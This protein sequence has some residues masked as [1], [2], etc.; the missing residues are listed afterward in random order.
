MNSWYGWIIEQSL[1][2]QSF[3]D[4]VSTIKMKSEEED[5]KEHIV[6]VPISER[7]QPYNFLNSPSFNLI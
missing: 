2:N 5:W 7:S 4:M 6:E 1:D 3:F